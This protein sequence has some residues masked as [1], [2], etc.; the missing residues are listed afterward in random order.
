MTEHRLARARY[1]IRDDL[2][3]GLFGSVSAPLGV[4]CQECAGLRE[5]YQTSVVPATEELAE[6]YEYRL[7]LD[8]ARIFD[9][10]TALIEEFLPEEGHAIFEE[11]SYD[12]FREI[13]AY[14]GEEPSS[15]ERILAA[16][17]HYGRFFVEDVRYGF[18][19]GSYEPTIE[20]L[21]EQH[22]SVFV[23]CSV[24]YKARVEVFLEGLKLPE[25]DHLE[26]LETCEH[27]HRPVLASDPRA[28]D[29]MNEI[30]IKFSVLESFAM[31]PTNLEDGESTYHPSL[32]WIQFELDMSF[33]DEAARGRAFASFGLCAKSHAEARRM[34]ERR[35][36]ELKPQALVA[37]DLEFY[38]VTED[39]LGDD[40]MP[41]DRGDLAK[42]GIWFESGVEY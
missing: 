40:L 11:E 26:L 34:A 25:T 12:A 18:G 35:V 42:V 13:D 3:R 31:K 6:Q 15:K 37:R 8:S 19:A 39:D 2:N 10:V 9:V 36:G 30:D 32:F 23:A 7:L 29:L 1:I 4:V 38:R 20:V 22:S 5:A 14:M 27:E 17:R 24:E 41:K 28:S 16:W 33:T 21:L